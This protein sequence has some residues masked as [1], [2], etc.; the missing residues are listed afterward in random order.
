MKGRTM[1]DRVL[2]IEFNYYIRRLYKVFHNNIEL[3]SYLEG[4]CALGDVDFTTIVR[5]AMLVK[6]NQG[7]MHTNS[8]ISACVLKA[9]G[10]SLRDI[11]KIQGLNLSTVYRH[12][13]EYKNEDL[14]LYRKTEDIEFIEI[15]RFMDTIKKL[16]SI[17]VGGSNG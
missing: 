15:K 6:Y 1:K 9:G 7:S 2:E 4:V 5:L 10:Y 3:R 8:V 17:Q 13:R 11:A 16:N 12:L 14:A